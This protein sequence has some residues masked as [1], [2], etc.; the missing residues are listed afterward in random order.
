MDLKKLANKIFNMALEGNITAFET[1]AYITGE[2]VYNDKKAEQLDRFIEK[3]E[4]E[5]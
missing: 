1:I 5:I 3:L 4:K 2:V